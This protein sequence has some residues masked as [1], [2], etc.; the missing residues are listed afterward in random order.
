[1]LLPLICL[2]GVGHTVR[3]K[4]DSSSLPT[5]GAGIA[6][7]GI[8]A[9]KYTGSPSGQH[10][11]PAIRSRLPQVVSAPTMQSEMAFHALST[12][13]TRSG[14]FRPT[15]L[16]RALLSRQF[17]ASSPAKLASE[18]L[19]QRQ[20]HHSGLHKK[21]TVRTL[22]TN[23][24][25]AVRGVYSTRDQKLLS[26]WSLKDGME[27]WI[28]L[29]DVSLELG[30]IIPPHDGADANGR[31]FKIGD[32]VTTMTGKHGNIR[33]IFSTRQDHHVS[34]SHLFSIEFETVDVPSS[35][36]YKPCELKHEQH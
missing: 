24:E 29:R 5:R 8:R 7:L 12:P 19:P 35:Q 1:M 22:D 15:G 4:K 16:S 6:R 23:E 9:A 17:H 10:P 31:I 20:R 28:P 36:W 11:T 2:L 26:C 21:H 25:F 30:Y 18:P 3:M 32:R 34:G 13:A 27:S 14:L 33:S